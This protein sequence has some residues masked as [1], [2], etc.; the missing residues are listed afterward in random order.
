MELKV[1]TL[2]YTAS[3]TISFCSCLP[4]ASLPGLDFRWLVSGPQTVFCWKELLA[5]KEIARIP[6]MFALHEAKVTNEI[7]WGGGC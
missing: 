7:G 2:D 4:R 3:S 6:P 1:G 5:W